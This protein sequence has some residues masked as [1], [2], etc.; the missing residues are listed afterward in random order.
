MLSP[1][2]RRQLNYKHKINSDD[3]STPQK[4]QNIT[5]E[6]QL[7]IRRCNGT[8]ISRSGIQLQ[9]ELWQKPSITKT[10]TGED[11][12]IM[13]VTWLEFW[14]LHC[15]IWHTTGICNANNRC[16][17]E[18]LVL[19]IALTDVSSSRYI[20]PIQFTTYC[21]SLTLLISFLIL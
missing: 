14:S 2:N 1:I 11:D 5:E 10:L 20:Y 3:N 21:F 18:E 4:V 9:I 12:T 16:Y 13:G 15:R 6:N 17:W 7:F 19:D 8:E